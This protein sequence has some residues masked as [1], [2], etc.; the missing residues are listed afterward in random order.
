MNLKRRLRV[1]ILLPLRYNNKKLIQ[2][3]Y[4]LKTE[5][6]LANRYGG[7]TA[8]T[9]RSGTWISPRDSRIYQD[10]SSGFYVDCPDNKKTITSLNTY[11]E[12]LKKRFKQKK[13]HIAFYRVTLLTG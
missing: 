7:C 12:V 11:S 10:I 3:S 6:E 13:M 5:E 9:P 2:P 4:F 8:L 1:E